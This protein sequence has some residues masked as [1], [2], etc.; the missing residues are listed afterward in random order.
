MKLTIII[1]V[2]NEAENI[3]Q[4]IEKIEAKVK[5]PHKILI[6]Y[7]FNKDTTVPIVKK[8]QKKFPNIQL[9]RNKL[10][11]GVLNAIKSGF[12]QVKEGAVLVT[13]ADLS[14]DPATINKMF[15]KINEGFDIVGGSRYIQ[16]GGKKGGPFLK[17][18]LSYLAGLTTPLLLGIPIYDL[19]NAFKM[20]KKEVLKA[21]KIESAGG[22]E[23]S[24]EIIIKAHFAG[25]KI[26]EVPTVWHD[27][28]SGRSRFKFKE[29]LPKYIH[30]YF[31]GIKKRA[32]L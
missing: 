2:Y 29:W 23:L 21:I 5:Y 9:L 27:R 15:K 8:L 12:N 30:W 17:S 7:D 6:I 31:W 13:M 22:F 14:D 1:P 10:G 24:E 4:A 25:F 28:T 32:G 11:K 26:T 3:T 18:L 20:Y 16:G 19:T